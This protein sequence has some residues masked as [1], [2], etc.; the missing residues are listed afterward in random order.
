MQIANDVT[1]MDK[2]ELSKYLSFKMGRENFGIGILAIKE[3]IEYGNITELPMMPAFVRGAINLRG[4]IV[5]IMD[6][7][8][9]LGRKSQEVTKR[10]CVVIIEIFAQGISMDIG[11]VVDAV[12]E[13]ID[14]LPEDID[15]APSF[16]GTV[17]TDFLRGMGKIGDGFLILLDINNIIS[18]K[19]M[20]L[21]SDIQSQG[22]LEHLSALQTLTA[23]Q[24]AGE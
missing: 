2:L 8:I 22:G 20:E 9:R 17:K 12:N 24:S 21:M 7:A 5:P 13:V 18:A 15:P 6:L 4:H 1:E 14:I 10:T 11:V 23:D 3:I 19:E 16:G